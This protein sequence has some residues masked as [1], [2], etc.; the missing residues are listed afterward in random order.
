MS[1]N[2]NNEKSSVVSIIIV[3]VLVLGL[4]YFLFKSSPDNSQAKQNTT[5][6]SVDSMHGGAAMAENSDALNSLIGKPMP[7]VQLS[8]KNGKVYTT[9]D[10]KGK[11]TVLFFSEGLM[12]YPACWN[13]MVAFGTDPR[14]NSADVSAVSIVVDSPQDWQQAITKMPD[15]A[16]TT[17]LFD[18]GA[19]VS[20]QM[21][22]LTTASS[23]H[24]GSL[25]G[26]TYVVL[27]KEGIVKYVFDDPN[28]APG[29]DMLWTKIQELNKQ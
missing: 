14:F 18:T 22:M 20:R 13:Q 5:A 6:A 28:M 26:H 29:N 8:D 17:T 15:L 16:K 21:G 2:N 9:A 12:C 4:G 27:D 7:D 10:F 25:P 24:R 11:N 3:S 19:T 1:K 23:M